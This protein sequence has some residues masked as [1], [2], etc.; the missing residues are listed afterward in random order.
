MTF[1]GESAIDTG[2]PRRE[3][4]ELLISQGVKEFC[5]GDNNMNT[6]AQN[7]AAVQV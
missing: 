6:F 3:F 2:G 7:T 5:I 1:V 4:W